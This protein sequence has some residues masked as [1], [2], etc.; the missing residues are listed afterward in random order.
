MTKYN[1]ILL[2]SLIENEQRKLKILRDS[3]TTVNE[4][5]ASPPR[6]FSR[7]LRSTKA[8]LTGKLKLNIFFLRNIQNNQKMEFGDRKLYSKTLQNKHSH[9]VHKLKIH[10][11]SIFWSDKTILSS[12]VNL[13][14]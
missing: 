10:R 14:F 6:E 12:L 13:L 7:P 4:S 3:N 9:H 5:F 11:N 8:V 1:L 2:D